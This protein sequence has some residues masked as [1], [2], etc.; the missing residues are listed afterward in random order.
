MLIG[1]SEFQTDLYLWGKNHFGQLGIPQV[2]SED[3]EQVTLADLQKKLDPQHYVAPVV[4]VLDMP[5]VQ[6]ACGEEH[7]AILT[8]KG[9][10][11]T[12]GSNA[13]GQVGVNVL[14]KPQTETSASTLG[15]FRAESARS[16]SSQAS[17]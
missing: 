5:I 12:M 9:L 4:A 11:Y 14:K 3:A 6:V 8:E 13:S 7:T 1:A 17:K 15:S 10:V 16:L 2:E